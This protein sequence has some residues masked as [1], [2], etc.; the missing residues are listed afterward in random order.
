MS[1]NMAPARMIELL[2]T[3]YSHFDALAEKYGVE[4]IRTIGENYMAARRQ[5]S[6]PGVV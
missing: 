2:N 5:K 1:A 6:G 4:K 3:I